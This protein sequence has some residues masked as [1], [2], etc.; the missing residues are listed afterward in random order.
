MKIT[1]EIPGDL[2]RRVKAR[3]VTEGRSVREVAEELFHRYVD[4]WS[5]PAAETG[6][7]APQLI[8]GAP[9]P[10]WFGLLRRFARDA[11]GSSIRASIGRGIARER[12]L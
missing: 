2:Y 4:D 12:K 9:A 6:G 5:E 7:H 11:K 1:I 10:P 8:D 3:S